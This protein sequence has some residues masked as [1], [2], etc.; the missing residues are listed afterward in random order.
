MRHAIHSTDFVDAPPSTPPFALTPWV[1][2]RSLTLVSAEPFSGKSVL[3]SA[4]ACAIAYG[5]PFLGTW[6]PMPQRCLYLALDSPS[7]DTWSILSKIKHGMQIESAVWE[8]ATW[9]ER[10]YPHLGLVFGHGFDLMRGDLEAV[11]GARHEHS[12]RVVF[13]DTLRNTHALDESDAGTMSLVMRRL[14]AVAERGCAVVL[15]HHTAKSPALSGGYSARGSTVIPAAA[16]THILLRRRGEVV[17]AQWVKGRGGDCPEKL[18]FRMLWDDKTM[19]FESVMPTVLEP[20][21]AYTWPALLA[22][23]RL[24][25]P[26]LKR[27][28]AAEGWVRGPDKLWRVGGVGEVGEKTS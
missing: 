24:Y 3:F 20:G 27:K 4:L 25:P 22:L 15:A 14:R 1:R 13:I 19:Q 8:D 16:D 10:T 23:F 5:R 6:P 18:S 26:D 17:R 11:L 21:R 12:P 7:W 28:L 9:V 2:E